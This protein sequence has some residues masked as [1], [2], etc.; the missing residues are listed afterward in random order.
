[1]TQLRDDMGASESIQ[2]PEIGYH[3]VKIT[4]DSPAEKC[5]LQVY[6]DYITH[7]NGQTVVLRVDPGFV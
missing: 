2:R 5:G 3:V 1:M 6:F 7:V 4:K